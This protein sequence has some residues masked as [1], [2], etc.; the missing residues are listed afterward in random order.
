[1][2][3]T[4]G[5]NEGL[6]SLEK[7]YVRI[8]ATMKQTGIITQLPI[9]EKLGVMGIDGNEYPVPS[10]EQLQVIFTHNKELVEK[11]KG[12]GFTQLIL[13]PI[14]I[15]ISQLIQHVKN[16]I[17]RHAEKGNIFQSKHNSTDGDKLI[18]VNA[19]D[20]IWIW[21]RVRQIMDTPKL[22]YFPQVY[23]N[24][25]HEGLTKEEL[26][27]NSRVCGIP[28]WS[29]GLIEPILIM[30]HQGQGKV[31]GGRKQLEEYF[32]PRD[33][34][35]MLNALPYQGETGWTFEDFLT[36]FIIRLETSN[37]ISH[38]RSDRNTLWLLGAYAPNLGGNRLKDLVS[39]GYWFHK[40]LYLSV[41]RSNNKLRSCVA[42][43]IVRLSP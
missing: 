12:Q 41:H 18:Q 36:H 20:P 19:A 32:T 8:I 22:I 43:S 13:T 1:L 2:I 3:K 14:A 6:F 37:Q 11:K 29:V 34:L 26:I 15:P 17:L 30:P 27:P 7:E 38:D 35:Q 28:G 33:Y 42:R 25:N 39:V 31:I 23:S 16:T 40:R 9:T 24:H 10:K 5:T 4:S 21:D